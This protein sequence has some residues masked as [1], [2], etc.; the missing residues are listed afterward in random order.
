MKFSN[1]TLSSIIGDLQRLRRFFTP[2]S[3]LTTPK[4]FISGLSRSTI[5]E[6]LFNAFA[7]FGRLLK[8]KVII[9]RASGRSEGFGFVTYETIED[10]EKASEGMN[11]KFLDGWV[12]FV[13]PARPRE[14]LPCQPPKQDT[15]QSETGFTT[16]NTIGWY[17]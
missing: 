12:I 4:L 15:Q 17:G 2:N 11:A 9:N 10:A 5:D 16:N 7:S 8:A 1:S 3:T 13:D 14:P 6:N